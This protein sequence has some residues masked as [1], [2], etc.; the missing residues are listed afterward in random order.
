MR[1][2]YILMQG[3]VTEG[4]QAESGPW[5]TSAL[6]PK[7]KEKLKKALKAAVRSALF[8][9]VYMMWIDIHSGEV[10]QI[11]IQILSLTTTSL[12]FFTSPPETFS[13]WGLNG[14]IVKAQE[15]WIIFTEQVKR[16]EKL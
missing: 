12:L 16:T 11:Q 13:T 6:P 14:G 8:G 2:K 7:K 5:V 9:S 4:S 3:W 1:K 15:D 10:Q